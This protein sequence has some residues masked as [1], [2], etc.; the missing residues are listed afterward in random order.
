MRV[1]VVG[2][3]VAGLEAARAAALRGHSVVLFE[4]RSVLG[5]RARLAGLRSGR[6]RWHRYID[7]LR[8]EAEAAGAE[9]RI[10]VDA[11]ADAVLA[12]KPDAV[13]V[14]TGS[15]LRPEARIPG[16]V[17]VLDVDELLEGGVERPPRPG[18]GLRADPRR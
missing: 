17:P 10:A 13:I 6:E 7:W 5:G 2:G 3:G 18:P 11:D 15:I 1:V 4:R 8:T 9:I 14:A 12:E 16:P